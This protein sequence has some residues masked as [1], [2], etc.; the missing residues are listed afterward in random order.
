MIY[1]NELYHSGTPRHSGRYPWGSGERPYQGDNIATPKK[2]RLLSFKERKEEKKRKE[3]LSDPTTPEFEKAKRKALQSG[4]ATEILQFKGHLTT[5]EMQK[6]VDRINLERKLSEISTKERDDGW[7]AV[8]NAMKK[9]GN[10]KDWSNTA[11]DIYKLMDQ[12]RTI[13]EKKAKSEENKQ[14]NKKK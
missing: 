2:R 4:T 13:S 8:N 12:V 5:S 9:V 7:N 10:V 6:A 1:Q 14:G 11:L 3:L